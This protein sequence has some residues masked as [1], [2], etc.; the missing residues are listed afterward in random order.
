MAQ[1]YYVQ[2]YKREKRTGNIG[3]LETH[4]QI[5]KQSA[6]HMAQIRRFTTGSTGF[7]KW[8]WRCTMTYIRQFW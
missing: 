1:K 7:R 4:S 5:D 6:Y 3:T 8:D 2:K